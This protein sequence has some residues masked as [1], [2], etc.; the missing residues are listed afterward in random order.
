MLS[1]ELECFLHGWHGFHRVGGPLYWDG[2]PLYRFG[3]LSTGLQ[4]LRQGWNA[5]YRVGMLSVGLECF[6][7]GWHGFH[8]VGGPLYWDGIP[9]YRFGML[10]TGLE[11]FLQG[12]NTFVRGWNAL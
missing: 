1:V 7:H 9:L 3:M 8:R 4:R 10:S 5:F 11:L 12:W 6:L 2:I